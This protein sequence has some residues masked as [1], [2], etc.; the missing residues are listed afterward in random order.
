MRHRYAPKFY[1]PDKIEGGEAL[2]MI[3]LI[4]RKNT[5]EDAAQSTLFSIRSYHSHIEERKEK[6][7]NRLC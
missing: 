4:F 5:S 6:G 2:K 3:S 7:Y 1:V